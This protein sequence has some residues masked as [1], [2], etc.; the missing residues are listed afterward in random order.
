MRDVKYT[1]GAGGELRDPRSGA[2]SGGIPEADNGASTESLLG[3]HQKFRKRLGKERGAPGIKRMIP[4][5]ASRTSV[6]IF[7]AN[8]ARGGQHEQF[9]GAR[10]AVA[11]AARWVPN[12]VG[13]AMRWRRAHGYFK[14]GAEAGQW[15]D[16]RCRGGGRHHGFRMIFGR[17]RC[18]TGKRTGAPRG[19]PRSGSRREPHGRAWYGAATR[20]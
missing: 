11:T 5:V 16:H 8:S 2:P 18:A 3:R 15:P 6:R 1:T 20:Q 9:G 14:F 10:T 4:S 13:M 12:R 19:A 17:S 7:C